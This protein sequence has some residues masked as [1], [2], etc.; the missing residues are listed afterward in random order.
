MI[1]LGFSLWINKWVGMDEITI[2]EWMSRYGWGYYRR[3]NEW[4]VWMRFYGWMN[5][6]VGL[7]EVTMDEWM[8]RY[9]WG[10]YG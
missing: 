9:E 8:S 7:D 4:E 10:F 5:E 3:M 2:D 1:F 6:W